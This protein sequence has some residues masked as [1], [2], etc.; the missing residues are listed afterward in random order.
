[1]ESDVIT[2]TSLA[3]D[4]FKKTT[5]DSLNKAATLPDHTLVKEDTQKGTAI[6]PTNSANLK[7]TLLPSA[8]R[9]TGELG[10]SYKPKMKRNSTQTIRVLVKIKNPQSAVTD[11]LKQITIDEDQPLQSEIANYVFK[12]IDVSIYKYLSIT[13]TDPAGDFKIDSLSPGSRQLIDTL[14]GNKW[15]WAIST[16]T[17]KKTTVLILNIIAE[18]PDG[19]IDNFSPRRIAINIQ[20]ERDFFRKMYDFIHDDPEWLLTTLIIP[21]FVWFR[22]RYFDKKSSL[23]EPPA[24]EAQV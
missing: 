21:A 19:V 20:L 6:L 17:D 24:T 1:M 11:Q 10:Y 9:R 13:L 7:D 18:K 4:T 5:T 2:K 16:N 22:K 12:S 8:V 3:I 15:E 14:N 23:G